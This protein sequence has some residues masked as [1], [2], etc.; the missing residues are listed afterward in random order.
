RGVRK[1][2]GQLCVVE[3]AGERRPQKGIRDKRSHPNLLVVRGADVVPRRALEVQ[4][5]PALSEPVLPLRL[6]DGARGEEAGGRDGPVPRHALGHAA[7]RAAHPGHAYLEEA[8]ELGARE[9][10]RDR[11]ESVL[12]QDVERTRPEPPRPLVLHDVARDEAPPAP[13]DAALEV[14]PYPRRGR[15]E[16]PLAD[17][18]GAGS[19]A[20]G[21]APVPEEGQL[22]EVRLGPALDAPGVVPLLVVFFFA[23]GEGNA[24]GKGVGKLKTSPEPE[25]AP[26][27][28]KKTTHRPGSVGR[29][30]VVFARTRRSGSIPTPEFRIVLPLVEARADL[31]RAPVGP[32]DHGVAVAV[33]VA[34]DTVAHER[35]PGGGGRAGRLA[36]HGVG[37]APLVAARRAADVAGPGGVVEGDAVPPLPLEVLVQHGPYGAA[38]R[39]LFS[40]LLTPICCRSVWDWDGIS[41]PGGGLALPSLPPLLFY[42]SPS[43]WIA[44]CPV[45]VSVQPFTQSSSGFEIPRRIGI[46][47]TGLISPRFSARSAN[48]SDQ[49]REVLFSLSACGSHLRD[50][51]TDNI[52]E[53]HM[54]DT[55]LGHFRTVLTAAVATA[56][57]FTTASPPPLAALAAL[58]R[59]PVGTAGD[60][61][62]RRRHGWKSKYAFG[63]RKDQQRG[64][65]CPLCRGTIPP[66]QEEISSI[67]MTQFVM[68]KTDKSDPSYEGYARKV[69]QFEAEYGEDWE[70][71]AIEYDDDYVNLP[72]YVFEA[73]KGGNF[74]TTILHFKAR[75]RQR[76]G[77]GKCKVRMCWEHGATVFSSSVQRIRF[78]EVLAVEWRGRERHEF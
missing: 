5:V 42:A 39:L 78:D 10:P 74:R 40:Y 66:S 25:R 37:E 55:E 65:R 20:G 58:R 14:V 69:K 9:V 76:Q 12:R 53:A 45:P 77:L 29:R 63:Y 33:P 1:K 44:P 15:R 57:L 38:L 62:E 3:E 41:R 2:V 59:R 17:A 47:N 68:K 22:G 21:G 6:D 72:F 31:H 32:G 24:A 48:V 19:A 71:T 11:H 30:G 27:G 36:L 61:P 49:S 18:G 50:R 52:L 26:E 28:G 51:K 4:P 75:Q 67:K 60:F 54:Q 73:A 23:S 8:P 34:V 35:A 13:E 43:F 64:R 16:A 70:G 7:Q 56:V 46:G